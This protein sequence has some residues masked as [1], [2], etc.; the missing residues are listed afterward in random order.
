MN[1]SE[2]SFTSAAE[3]NPESDGRLR[4]SLAGVQLKFSA[5]R[6]AAGGLTIPTTGRGGQWIGDAITLAHISL[7]IRTAIMHVLIYWRYDY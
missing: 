4:F 7:G 2:N 3:A 6:D 1:R 5:V